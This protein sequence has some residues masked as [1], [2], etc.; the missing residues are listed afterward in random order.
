MDMVNN[1]VGTDIGVRAAVS[2]MQPGPEAD[3]KISSQVIDAIKGGKLVVLDS[4]TTPPR[5]GRA[6]DLALPQ[7]DTPAGIEPSGKP[8]FTPG[9]DISDPR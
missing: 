2:G 7:H 3:A 9:F 8:S 4:T 6:S 1:A 5:P